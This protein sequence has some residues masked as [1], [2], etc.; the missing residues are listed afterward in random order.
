MELLSESPEL[1]K[2]VRKTLLSAMVGTAVEWY[3]FYLYATAAA[4]DL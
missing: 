3:D 2:L 4:V 1:R